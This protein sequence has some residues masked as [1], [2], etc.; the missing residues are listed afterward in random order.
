MRGA[1]LGL[2]FA[3]VM[4]AAW[5]FLEHGRSEATLVSAPH[6]LPALEPTT[7]TI[8]L[9][10]EAP[11]ESLVPYAQPPAQEGVPLEQPQP[12]IAA[13]V[14]PS[15]QSLSCVE[16]GPFETRQLADSVIAAFA[17]DVVLEVQART[18]VLP[19]VYRVY[20]SPSDNREAASA[21]LEE[22]SKA[23]AGQRLAIETFLIPRGELAN[24][25]A[26][27]LF[28][29]QRNAV[30]VKEQV[31]AL[32]FPVTVRE[33]ERREEL[34]WLASQPFDFE[35]K[36]DTLRSS[37]AQIAPSAQLLEKLCQTIAQD[38]HLP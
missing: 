20:L 12:L 31:E 22:L 7:A 15:P 13:E 21:R 24:G 1:V 16:L 18:Q 4:F 38:I 32:G 35:E 3:N 29:E 5:V 10:V 28:S 6:A 37:L 19:S 25:I 9:L 26:L 27:G 34:F 11:A 36:V 23:L 8:G 17:Q 33:E 2:L 30:N 14:I